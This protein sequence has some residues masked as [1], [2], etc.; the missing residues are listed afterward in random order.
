MSYLD[1][2]YENYTSGMYFKQKYRKN[3]EEVAEKAREGESWAL[4]AF[5][6]MGI[7]LGNAINT[8]IMA[9]D[10][11]LVIIGGSIGKAREFYQESM[12]ESIRKIPFP[13]VLE[14]FR[15]EFTDTDNIAVLGAAALCPDVNT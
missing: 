9:V 7:H 2:I 14:N 15:V 13:S 12:W 11:P 4:R 10:P 1:G 5:Q 3:G 8:I 6:E